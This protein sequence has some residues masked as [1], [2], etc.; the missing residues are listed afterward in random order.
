LRF[1]NRNPSSRLLSRGNLERVTRHLIYALVDPRSGQWRYIGKSSSGLRRPREH[2]RAYFLRSSTHKINWVKSLL[3]QGLEPQIEVLEEL[4]GPESLGEAE[5]E[6]IAAA[7]AAGCQLTNETDGGE[8]LW[9]R[10]HTRETRL[11]MSC[12]RGGMPQERRVEAAKLYGSGL[13][14]RAV[15]EALGVGPKVAWRILKMEGVSLR[16]RLGRWMNRRAA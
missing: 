9:G 10:K 11:K 8:G 2:V 7:R 6:W 13:S 16:P 3:A 5:M 15:A 14:T 4:Q 1:Y 12:V